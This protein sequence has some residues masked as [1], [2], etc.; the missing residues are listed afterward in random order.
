MAGDISLQAIN[1]YA[2]ATD[3]A[4]QVTA[5][6]RSNVNATEFQDLVK[7]NFNK[8]SKMSPEQIIQQVTSAS[9]TSQAAVTS[10]S[11]NG[12]KASFK[13]LRSVL[14]KQETTSRQMVS[15]EA[16]TLDLVTATTEAQNTLQVMTGIRD[17]VID[18]FNQL[19]NM[20][21]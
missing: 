18:G 11:A 12:A 8:F 5:G 19:L 3:Q 20:Q 21:I 17:K 9:N 10:G 15:G 13:Q 4:T 2:K 7:V 14:S 16:S 6:Q 1:A